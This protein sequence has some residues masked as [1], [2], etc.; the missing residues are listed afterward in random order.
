MAHVI[1]S[2]RLAPGVTREAFEDWVRTKDQ[3]A[4]RS[5]ARVASFET[6]RVTGHLIGGVGTGGG[7]GRAPSAAKHGDVPSPSSSPIWPASPAR[8]CP[9]H[10]CRA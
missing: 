9:A 3:P 10:W 1:I 7:G 6:Y 2:Y 5:L 4:M 8:T